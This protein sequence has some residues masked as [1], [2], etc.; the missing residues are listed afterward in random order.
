MNVRTYGICKGDCYIR[1]KYFAKCFLRTCWCLFL[2]TVTKKEYLVGYQLTG[3]S[4][5]V[6]A[7]GNSN[8]TGNQGQVASPC[9]STKLEFWNPSAV[10]YFILI[11][12]SEFN[13]QNVSWDVI[14]FS[15]FIYF[16][17]N[18]GI[19]ALWEAQT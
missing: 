10:K 16:P 1:M 17:W 8:R 4:Y 18:V 5:H 14:S 19:F 9:G 15:S 3:F 6:A 13:T 12:Y 11:F 7:L 2:L